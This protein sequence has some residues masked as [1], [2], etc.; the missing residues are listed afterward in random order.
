MKGVS[1]S[2]TEVCIKYSLLKMLLTLLGIFGLAPICRRRL[3]TC[4]LPFMQANVRAVLPPYNNEFS[5]TLEDSRMAGNIH[6]PGCPTV[7]DCLHGLVEH[8]QL[9]HVCDV[10]QPAGWHLSGPGKCKKVLLCDAKYIVTSFWM[11]GVAPA[12]TSL[13]AISS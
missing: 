12:L 3:T 13:S 4:T 7:M 6:C 11:C 8:S 9:C 10:P 5:G 1:P 2:C